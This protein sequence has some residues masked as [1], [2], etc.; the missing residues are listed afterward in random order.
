[1][2]LDLLDPAKR[3]VAFIEAAA[4]DALA[5][6]EDLA[7]DGWRLRADDAGTRRGN[8]VLPEAPGSEPLARKIAVAEAF[9]RRRRRVPRVQLSAAAEPAGLDAAL[10]RAGW[11]LEEGARVMVL[12]LT[13][14]PVQ[15]VASGLRR[16][17]PDDVGWREVQASVTS[18][19]VDDAVRRADGLRA[20]GRIPWHLCLVDEHGGAVAAALAVV[21]PPRA[22]LGLFQ[23]ATRPDARRRGW[24]RRLLQATLALGA[25]AG[26]ERAYLQVHAANEAALRLYAGVGFTGHH[27]YHYRR[28]PDEAVR[29]DRR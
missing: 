15:P 21:D 13:G 25:E 17:A 5:P 1:M 2:T 14:P 8:S 29:Q 19:R 10:E 28:A 12:D 3:R 6:S 18:A 11:T 16:V 24:A 23:F 9:Y 20:A 27:P 4:A 26:A 7:L 22:T